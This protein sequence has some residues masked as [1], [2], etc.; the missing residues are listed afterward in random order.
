MTDYTNNYFRMMNDIGTGYQ[1]A[2]AIRAKEKDQLMNA[3]NWD[4]VK[5]WNQREEK[6]F[7]FPFSRGQMNAYRAWQN[8]AANESSLNGRSILE[9]SDLP[10]DKDAHDFIST[11]R[12]AGITEF[13]ITDRSTALMELLHI[14]ADEEGCKMVSLCKITRSEKRWGGTETTETPGILM[15]ID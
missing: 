7:P 11:L 8:S 13:A 9:V 3:N 12:E 1:N 4:A 5:A 14:L 2:K 10:W 6:E 15:N